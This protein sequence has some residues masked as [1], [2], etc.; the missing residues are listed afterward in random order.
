MALD[1]I[2]NHPNVAPFIGKQLIQHL[3]TSNPSPAY[4]ARVSAVFADNGS[5]VRGDMAAVVKAILTDPEARGDTPAQ[6]NY[7]HLRE[8]ALMRVGPSCARAALLA[9]HA[10]PVCSL[11]SNDESH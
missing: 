8:P 9:K 3:V 6:S 1:D 2:F 5:G 4:I 10:R 11:P 7:G